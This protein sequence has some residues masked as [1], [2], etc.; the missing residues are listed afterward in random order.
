VPA[1]LG[2]V[3]RPFAEI[4]PYVVDQVTSLLAEPATLPMSWIV[5]SK[6]TKNGPEVDVADEIETWYPELTT[7]LALANL[8]GLEERVT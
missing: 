5:P 3:S 4:E 1:E 8:D 6:G 7:A 2:A